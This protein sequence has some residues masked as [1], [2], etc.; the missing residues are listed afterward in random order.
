[1]FTPRSYLRGGQESTKPYAQT[2]SEPALP[3]TLATTHSASRASSFSYLPPPKCFCWTRHVSAHFFW[4]PQYGPAGKCPFNFIDAPEGHEL[5]KERKKASKKVCF[6]HYTLNWKG[7]KNQLETPTETSG[8]GNDL[9]HFSAQNTYL[10]S[11]FGKSFKK[12]TV[13][14]M[15]IYRLYQIHFSLCNQNC[16]RWSCTASLSITI[17]KSF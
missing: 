5:N 10:L 12:L 9:V 4:C 6:K 13:G 7:K 16:W 1:M 2:W 3:S 17:V 15:R 11:H 14:E 8:Y